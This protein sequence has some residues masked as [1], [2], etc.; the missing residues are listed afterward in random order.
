MNPVDYRVWGLMQKRINKT[1]M[2]DT[3]ELKQRLIE[4]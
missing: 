4:T 3:A 1:A 2:R